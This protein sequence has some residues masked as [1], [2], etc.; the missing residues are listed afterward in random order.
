MSDTA[1]ED[2]QVQEESQEEEVKPKLED[3][4]HIIFHIKMPKSWSKKKKLEMDGEPHRQTPDV[5][6]LGK[7]L[8][9]SVFG[10]DAHISDIRIT[11][12][13]ANMGAIEIRNPT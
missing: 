13:W 6:N 5:D 8:L 11:K 12:V 3:G 10:N 4:A 1:Q 7:A 2:T 9:D